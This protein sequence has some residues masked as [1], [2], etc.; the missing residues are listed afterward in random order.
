MR[1]GRSLPPAAAFLGWQDLCHGIAG[2]FRPAQALRARVEELR[3]ALGVTHIFPVSSGTAALKVTLEALSSLSSATEV[4]IPA[5]TC[6]SVPAAVLQAGLRPVLCDIDETTLGID[7]TLLP[8]ALTSRT[9]C[10]IP[11]HLFGI[12]SDIERTN[13]V[14]RK[15]EVFVVEDAAQALGGRWNDKPLGT[16][17]DVGIFSFGR[18]KNVTCGSGGVIVTNSD[19]IAKA[20]AARF[21]S[22]SSP[23]WLESIKDFISTV[24]MATFIRPWLYWIP[25]ALPLLGL[26]TTVFPQDVPVKRLSGFKA[27]VLRNWRSYLARSNDNRSNTVGDLGRYLP[28]VATLG[29]PQPLLRL[30]FFA[31]DSAEKMRLFLLSRRQG[32]GLSPAYP[33]S[34]NEIPDI[35]SL[36]AGQSFPTAAKVASRLLTLPTHHWLI[37]KDKQAIAELCRESCAAC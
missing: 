29:K 22:V 16:L 17:G 27:G 35:R 34:I 9:L 1:I 5:Y 12:P 18:G 33:T 31:A 21:R 32:L 4:V 26:G 24:L 20:I 19:R 7:H 2:I 8:H 37:E 13:A 28:A 10:V 11:H 25:E 6:F 3:C 36:F 15:H 23:G 14:C 30:P